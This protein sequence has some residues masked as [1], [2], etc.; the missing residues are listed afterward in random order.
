MSVNVIIS[1]LLVAAGPSLQ[2]LGRWGATRLGDFLTDSDIFTNRVRLHQRW[3][4]DVTSRIYYLGFGADM[5]FEDRVLPVWMEIDAKQAY[6]YRQYKK[7]NWESPIPHTTEY[8]VQNHLTNTAYRLYDAEQAQKKHH[9]EAHQ[10]YL[11]TKQLNRERLKALCDKQI[12][13][14]LSNQ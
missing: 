9:P 8:A 3:S 1:S 7:L 14:D 10:E 5:P 2:I 12:Q 13:R 11:K 4:G 6:N